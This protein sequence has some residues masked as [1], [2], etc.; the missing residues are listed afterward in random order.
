MRTDKFTNALLTLMAIALVAIAIRPY[1]APEAVQA[2][3]GTHYPFYI[4]PVACPRW[5]PPGLWKSCCRYAD[6]KNLGLSNFYH[7]R[8]SGKRNGVQ[9]ADLTPFRAGAICI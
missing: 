3:S 2:Q 7:G 5:R 4:E 1:L 8:I 9:T 6:G